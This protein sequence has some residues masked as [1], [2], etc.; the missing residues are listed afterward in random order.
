MPVRAPSRLHPSGP[1]WGHNPWKCPMVRSLPPLSSSSFL[2]HILL[3]STV[4]LLLSSPG[5]GVWTMQRDLAAR[6]GLLWGVPEPQMRPEVNIPPFYPACFSSPGRPF[7]QYSSS[8]CP[9]GQSSQICLPRIPGAK[10][11]EG[12]RRRIIVE[13]VGQNPRGLSVPLKPS[14]DPYRHQH[15]I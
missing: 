12:R 14:Q 9:A 6:G 8:R 7:P 13:Q 2:L 10:G 1:V 15:R 11:M 4:V 3:F 5:R